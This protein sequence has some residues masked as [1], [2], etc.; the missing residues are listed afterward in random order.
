MQKKIVLKIFQI[1]TII[2][3]SVLLLFSLYQKYIKKSPLI[4]IG[5]L[6]IAIINSGSM[7]PTLNI[8]EMILIQEKKEYNVNDI[9]VFS[10]TDFLVTH[11]IIEV[12][13]KEIST[14]GDANNIKD[15]PISK[16]NIQGKVIYHSEILGWVLNYGIRPSILIIMIYIF[17]SSILNIKKVKSEVKLKVHK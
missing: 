15:E 3:L 13:E 2:L 6:G 7:Q 4:K 10:E 5:G 8:G 1:V 16:Q 9:V 17:F 11:R 14:K 12:N